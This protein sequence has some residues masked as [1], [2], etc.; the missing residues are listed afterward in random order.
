MVSRVLTC[1]VV[2]QIVAESQ[3]LIA[4]LLAKNPVLLAKV[5]NHLQLALVHPAGRD[6][7]KGE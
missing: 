3:P 7:Q 5:V 1:A 6:V 4:E 2:K